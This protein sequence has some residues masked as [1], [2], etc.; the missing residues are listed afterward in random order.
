MRIPH[1]LARA[2]FIAG[3]VAVSPL[4]ARPP[5]PID[6]TFYISV[7]PDS[8]LYNWGIGILRSDGSGGYN[9]TFQAGFPDLE[10]QITTVGR[11]EIMVYPTHTGAVTMPIPSGSGDFGYFILGRYQ[12]EISPGD[13]AGVT[14]GMLP[15][16]ATT[17]TSD[18]VKVWDIKL[19]A[20]S[21]FPGI[22]ESGVYSDLADP[23][24]WATS[25]TGTSPSFLSQLFAISTKSS[26]ALGEVGSPS[27]LDIALVTFS[28]AFPGG[29]VVLT[30]TPVPEASTWAATATVLGTVAFAWHR[31]RV[32]T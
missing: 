32:T 31:R 13:E 14:V 17:W 23:T 1:P 20:D 28:E 11:S 9:L 26:I 2:A 30:T 8:H 21:A 12:P 24:T 3:M 22:S 18:P 4:M 7:T 29:S 16:T 5:A 19:E 15:S 6:P 25:P 10:G 27:Q